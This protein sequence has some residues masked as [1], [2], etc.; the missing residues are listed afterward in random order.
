MYANNRGKYIISL[1]TLICLPISTQHQRS[2]VGLSVGL[3]GVGKRLSGAGI[4][5][6]IVAPNQGLFTTSP[7]PSNRNGG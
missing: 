1:I 5:K 4:F 2:N 7:K 3:F 6:V